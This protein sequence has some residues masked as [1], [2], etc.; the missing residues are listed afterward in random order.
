MCDCGPQHRQAVADAEGYIYVVC[1]KCKTYVPA[2]SE[3]LG[4][5]M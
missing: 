1:V 2:L 3:E 5:D 4:E